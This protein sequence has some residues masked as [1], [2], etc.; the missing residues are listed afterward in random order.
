MRKRTKY[1]VSE[2]ITKRLDVEEYKHQ[3][4]FAEAINLL[5]NHDEDKEE[6]IRL[7]DSGKF[8]RSG[9]II[10]WAVKRQIQRDEE[11]RT[12]NP[13]RG[14]PKGNCLITTISFFRYA[15]ICFKSS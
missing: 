9:D 2:E 15:C 11:D 14:V 8:D 1:N 5:L 6:L 10:G 7:I 12:D 3:E 13:S 4:R